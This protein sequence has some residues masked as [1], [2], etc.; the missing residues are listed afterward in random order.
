MLASLNA[1]ANTVPGVAFNPDGQ[2]V[3][4]ASW[5][6]T[7]ILWNLNRVVNLDQVLN[8]GCEWVKDYLQTQSQGSDRDLCQDTDR[9]L[10]MATTSPASK[11]CYPYLGKHGDLFACHCHQAVAV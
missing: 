11:D 10:S 7:V 3:A 1:H 2:L 4:S 9:N 8:F 5:D 6:K